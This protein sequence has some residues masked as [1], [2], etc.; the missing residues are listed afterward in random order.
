MDFDSHS[1]FSF[2]NFDCSKSVVIFG[3]DNSS[4]VYIDYK[5]KDILVLSKDPTKKLDDL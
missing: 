4:S 1:L 3:A 5:K 2:P